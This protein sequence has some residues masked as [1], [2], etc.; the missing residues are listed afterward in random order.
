MADLGDDSRLRYSDEPPEDL[1][2]IQDTAPLLEIEVD[3]TVVGA[4]DA[5]DDDEN[6]RGLPGATKGRAHARPWRRHRWYQV[7]SP[8]AVVATVALMLFVMVLGVVVLLIPLAR[9]IEDDLCRRHYG[10]SAPVPEEKCKVGEVQM[11]LAWLGGWAGVVNAITE[12]VVSFPWGLL[13]DRFGRKPILWASF[14]GI[15][16]SI[17]WSCFVISRPDLMPVELTLLGTLFAVFGGGPATAVT[18]IHAV[19]ADVA[20]DKASAFMWTSIGAIGGVVIGPALAAHMMESASSPWVPVRAACTALVPILV[21]LVIL[22]E[23]RPAGGTAE[24]GTSSD[25]IMKEGFWKML[26]AQLSESLSSLRSSVHMLRRASILCVM[27]SFFVTQP[28]TTVQGATLGL[29]FSKKFGWKMAQLGYFFS[30]RGLLTILVLAL[31]PLLIK[32]RS[33]DGGG[34][35]GGGGVGVGRDLHL[36]RASMLFMALANLLTGLGLEAV[37]LLAAGQ[38]ALTLSVG[39]GSLSRS[40]L[41]GL[42]GGPDQTARLYALAGMVET[43]GSLVSGPTLPWA[44]A[45]GVRAGG[46]W[47]G[48]PFWLVAVLCALALAALLCVRRDEPGGG[49]GA[50]DQERAEEGVAGRGSDAEESEVRP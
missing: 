37:P 29:T 19:I 22:P 42:A 17:C 25:T 27:P 9:L 18:V 41:A 34:G 35:G 1:T 31:L 4:S 16:M 47:M 20:T 28:V 40:L 3:D 13:A 43:V 39:S 21:A 8:R 12:L 32:S 33:K 10:T 44:F 7:R 30:A 5:E 23:T 26:R 11:R 45:V 38:L 36:A 50:G 48:I 15:L 49:C 46:A 6:D 24:A 14:A 2:S